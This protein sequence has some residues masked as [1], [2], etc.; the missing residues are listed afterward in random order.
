MKTKLLSIFFLALM[1]A[2]LC[3][4]KVSAQGPKILPSGINYAEIGQHI[5]AFVAEHQA[6]TAGLALAVFDSEG[7]IYKNFFGHADLEANFPVTQDTVFEWGSVSKLLVWVSVMQLEEQGLIDLEADIKTYLPD[8][9]LTN[10]KYPEPISMLNLMNHTPGFQEKIVNLFIEP[11]VEV[12]NLAENL[13]DV[14]PAQVYRPGDLHAYSNWG[15]ALAGYIVERISGKPFFQYVHDAIFE[16]LGMKNTGLAP[17]LSDNPAVSQARKQLRCYTSDRQ[18][19]AD[20]LFQIPLYPAG[21]VTGTLEDFLS[22]G[23]ALVKTPSPLFKSPETA[24]RLFQPT[25]YFGDSGVGLNSHGFWAHFYKVRTLGHGGNTAGGSSMLQIDPLSGTGM[26][27]MTNQA[28]EKTYNAKMLE[29]V[30]GKFSDSDLAGYNTAIPAGVFRPARAVVTGPLS[31]ASNSL[32]VMDASDLETFW[33]LEQKDGRER[34]VYAYTDLVRLSTGELILVGVLWGGLVLGILFALINLLGDGLIGS[35]V[36]RLR[37]KMAGQ[38]LPADPQRRWRLLSSALQ[39]LVL[40]NL[41]V[42]FIQVMTYQRLQSFLWQSVL[43][44]VMGI[45][46]IVLMVYY[47]RKIRH[48]GT[49]KQKW[50]SAASFIFLCLT[51][52]NILHWQLY[53]FWAF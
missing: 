9:F 51:A 36:R 46:I 38:P 41:A 43:F 33:V 19:I 12:N 8:G 13:Q 32:A 3:V 47:L 27:V 26:V 44:G 24:E 22:F 37:A 18:L 17:D 35:I 6:T 52:L 20:C 40:I 50:M 10:L 1:L 15:V 5:E 45:G 23:R 4:G 42:L 11:G 14:P 16:P 30:F 31:L 28:T 39:I 53:R 7:T 29:L 2:S 49:A 48:I 34:V 25:A 21:M